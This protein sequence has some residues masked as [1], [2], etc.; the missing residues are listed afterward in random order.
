M[1]VTNINVRT[2]SE[3]KS[4][5]AEIFNSLGLDMS[6]AINMFLRQTIRNE[7]LP[8]TIGVQPEPDKKAMRRPFKFGSLTGKFNMAD[9]FDAPIEDFKE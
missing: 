2:D 5:A 9:D 3:I 4:K 6:T 1:A 8:F 7:N